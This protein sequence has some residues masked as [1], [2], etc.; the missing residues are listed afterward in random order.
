MN[1]S[2]EKNPRKHKKET[3]QD[4]EKSRDQ[5]VRATKESSSK[6]SGDDIEIAKNMDPLWKTKSGSKLS[7]WESTKCWAENDQ[8]YHMELLFRMRQL[9]V[10]IAKLSQ[11]IDRLCQEIDRLS[12]ENDEPEALVTQLQVEI[13]KL[14]Q[15]IDQL[16]QESDQLSQEIDQLSQ[17]NEEPETLLEADEKMMQQLAK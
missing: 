14:S 13:A 10:E 9:R 8:E 17:D 4:E 5:H 12:Q 2:Q 11:V 3:K 1:P 6:L 7:N 16:C 15:V